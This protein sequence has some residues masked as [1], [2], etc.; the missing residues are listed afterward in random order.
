MNLYETID[1]EY[2]TALKGKDALK[3]S[4]LRMVISSVKM[5][6][7]QKNVKTAEDADILQII[8]KQIK[9]RK[10]SIDQFTKGNR[11]DLAAK[12][13]AELALLEAYMP[14][15]LSE[16]ELRTVVKTVIADLGAATKA[17]TG[18]VMKAVMEKVKGKADG[19]AVNQ[20]VSSLLQ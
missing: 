8:Q 7:I 9:Q 2:K 14:K 15:Q 12:E 5:L 20:I 16:D 13:A 19:K 18:K 1:S 6:E 4:V 11:Q 10:E 3:V 17:E